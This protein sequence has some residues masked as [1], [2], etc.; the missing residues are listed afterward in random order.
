MSNEGKKFLSGYLQ[1]KPDASLE[2]LKRVLFDECKCNV[3]ISTISRLLKKQS[4][5]L[6][7]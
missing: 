5:H 7:R 6:N 2:E 4:P 3:S 1:G